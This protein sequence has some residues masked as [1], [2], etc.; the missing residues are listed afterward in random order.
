MVFTMRSTLRVVML[1]AIVA[2]SVVLL[3]P[4][5]ALAVPCHGER[6][7]AWVSCYPGGQ[8][9]IYQNCYYAA[10]VDKCACGLN[11]P[12]YTIIFNN[13]PDGF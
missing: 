11:G 6:C 9:T 1:V 3:L 2:S 4:S 13:C 5:P 8:C 10:Q 12:Q 7:A